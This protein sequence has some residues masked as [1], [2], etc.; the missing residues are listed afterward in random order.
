MEKDNCII[1]DDIANI[2]DD[3]RPFTTEESKVFL[4]ISALLLEKYNKQNEIV[5]LDAG[6]GTGRLAVE[7]AKAFQ[8][9]A[10]NLKS[11][12]KLKL[13]CVDKSESMLAKL[14]YKISRDEKKLEK[15][16]RNNVEIII[17]EKDIRD[18]TIEKDKFDGIIA[19]WI[20]HTI[21]DWS[22]TLYSLSQL[23]SENGVFITFEEDSEL[24]DAIDGN[25]DT[26]NNDVVKK[27]WDIYHNYRKES[28]AQCYIP[29]RNRI[30][31]R[32][33]D[34]RINTL[35]N[36][37]GWFSDINT[38]DGIF[39]SWS[40]TPSLEWVTKNII[41]QSAF[42]NMRFSHN[43]DG[44]TFNITDFHK[45]L[46]EQLYTPYGTS[47]K[48]EYWEIKFTFKYHCYFYKENKESEEYRTLLNLIKSTIGQ[49]NTRKLDIVYNSNT[50]WKR[51]I[52]TT[53]SRIN[54]SVRDKRNVIFGLV[55]EIEIEQ[56]LYAFGKFSDELSKDSRNYRFFDYD[57][58]PLHDIWHNLTTG[59]EVYDPIIISFN[60][61]S[62]SVSH[63]SVYNHLKIDTRK[64]EKL[65]DKDS[66]QRRI[67]LSS[68]LNQS[69]DLKQLKR[70]IEN[71]GLLPFNM[72]ESLFTFFNGLLDIMRVDEVRF[73]YI[74]PYH[75][76]MNNET[77][78]LILLCKS[79]LSHKAFDYINLLFDLLLNEYIDEI[80][81]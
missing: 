72:R 71:I 39:D 81:E 41:Q 62:F 31:S 5:I 38:N 70:N 64:I 75:F 51:I 73:V 2:Y 4:E 20:F 25:Y 16:I 44:S 37:L 61:F 56:I 26:V 65:K 21:F 8:K 43:F 23:I 27:Y 42:T 14:K 58:L 67:E 28:L 13:Y 52:D 30:G 19:H 53:W 40:K 15:S 46:N 60:G 24:Y 18:I 77:L 17:E 55:P 49:K 68:L 3:T 32:V 80:S 36:S 7:F 63:Y 11:K 76:Q 9:Q 54:Y 66:N 50:F 12:T 48:K 59:L 6:T 29:A 22:T 74:F 69:E 1:F 47:P 34:R 45:R 35:L 10:S 78:G 79:Q 33:K 57:K